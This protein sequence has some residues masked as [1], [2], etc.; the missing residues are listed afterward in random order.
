MSFSTPLSLLFFLAH[1]HTRSRFL[2][3]ER[4][5]RVVVV[6]EQ[7]AHIIVVD[8]RERERDFCVLRLINWISFSTLRREKEAAES[9]AINQSS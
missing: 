7:Q 1:T 6:F 3:L 4:R 8:T 2:S 9:D 5:R